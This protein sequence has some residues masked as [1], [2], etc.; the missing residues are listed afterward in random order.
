MAPALLKRRA[1]RGK[2]DPERLQERLGHAGA[3]RPDGPL[4][5]L[6]GASVGESLS[7]LPLIDAL[8]AR[9]PDVA[10]LVTSG[11]VTSAELMAKRLPADA[12][13][14]YAPVDTPGAARRFVEHWKPQLTVFVESEIWPN[15][16]LA[17]KSGGSKL[18][19][20]SAR[21]S[22]KSLRN[23]SRLPGAARTLFAA[24][25]LVLAQDRATA[26]ALHRLGARNDGRL[27]LKRYGAPLPVD[28]KALKTMK[29]ALETRPMLLA[30]ST[31]P[32]EDEIVLQAFADAAVD[33]LLTIVPRHP[34]RA[35]NILALA[36]NA[37]FTARLRSR[38]DPLGGEVYIADTL[39]ELGLWFSLARA[40]LIGGSLR[41][42]PGGH[43]PVEAAQLDCPIVAGPYVENWREV[44]AD[45][46]DVDAVEVVP[47]TAALTDAFKRALADPAE[48][49]ARAERARHVVAADEGALSFA[50][51]GLI[52]LLP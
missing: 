7:L 22:P 52:T 43:N 38:G 28:A 12:L 9:R 25:D 50:L 41:P 4:V 15:L 31:H 14:Q 44:Y 34:A 39:G 8:R 33:A 49:N 13:H 10:I 45:L 16:V 51:E 17:A 19:L 21:F 1:G 29:A 6:H 46:I 26:S 20:L 40:A 42:G 11:T 23:W 32:G 47:D 27:N 37:G 2:E 35:E 48:G 30:A 36:E 5:W 24:F 18:A 3:P